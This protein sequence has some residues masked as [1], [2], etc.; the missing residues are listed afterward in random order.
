ML[1]ETIKTL[2]RFR[3]AWMGFILAL[4]LILS[5]VHGEPQPL[6]TSAAPPKDSILVAKD[7]LPVARTRADSVVLVRHHFNH[8]EQIIAGG[9]V[10]ACLVAMMAIMNNY[11]P[12]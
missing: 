8:K 4:L 9:V 7:S 11:N 10:M 5:L 3:P 6:Q 12:R 1:G 2:M